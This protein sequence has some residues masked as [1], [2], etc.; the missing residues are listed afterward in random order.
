MGESFTVMVT[1]SVSVR[2]P[3]SVTVSVN[4]IFWVVPTLGAV[5]DGVAVAAPVSVTVGAPLV[6]AHEYVREFPS[7]GSLERVPFRDT[8]A[9]SVTVWSSPALAVGAVLGVSSIV[10]IG[11][12]GGTCSTPS[13]TFS[14]NRTVVFADTA[15][16]VNVVL[17]AAEFCR[18]M[19]SDELWVHWW[20]RVSSGSTSEAVPL[21]VTVSPS[22]TFWGL[23]ASAVGG[24]CW[25]RRLP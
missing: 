18:V 10:M 21:S 15:G 5:N 11:G 4:T 12:G 9:P 24:P 20:A 8:V 14:V 2:E 17:R 13:V 6:W 19:V 16:A 7:S 1:V 23:P 22:V 25:Q 3:E